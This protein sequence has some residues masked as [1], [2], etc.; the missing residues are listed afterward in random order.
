MRTWGLRSLWLGFAGFTVGLIAWPVGAP[1]QNLNLQSQIQVYSPPF[2][3]Q[4]LGPSRSITVP[5]QQWSA[6]K[7]S[8]LTRLLQA[9]KRALSHGGQKKGQANVQKFA[10]SEHIKRLKELSLAGQQEYIANLSAEDIEQIE[11]QLAALKPSPTPI[12]SNIPQPTTLKVTLPILD[13]T[14]ETNVLK[15]DQNI[16]PDVSL[17]LGG[18]AQVTMGLSKDRPWDVAA[19]SVAEASA[20]YDQNPSKSLDVITQSAAYQFFL[21]ATDPGGAKI[22]PG[23]E[24]PKA[25]RDPTD[26]PSPGVFTVD[27]LLVGLQNQTAFVPTF[28][29]ET[30][31]L[32]TPQVVYTR[33]NIDLSGIAPCHAIQ[34]NA[35]GNCIYA[36]L[37]V[38]L[39]QTF[40][41]QPTQANANVA[42]GGT[43]GFR[44]NKTDL[45]LT[46]PTIVTGKTYETFA[47]GRRD[48]VLQ[49]GPALS[50]TP[51]QWV[52]ASLAITYYDQYSSVTAAAWHG[53]IIQPTL[54]IT[55]DPTQDLG[56]VRRAAD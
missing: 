2:V 56:L 36:D 6:F 1:A 35:A 38:G 54:S 29:A 26:K 47:G 45:V 20:R 3:A 11:Q 37:S 4:P 23:L 5:E 51:N 55:F 9:K 30:A 12:G 10:A 27:T 8:A 43:L 48:L 13:P 49:T 25:D 50:W 32:L 34:N 16:R 24:I 15:T 42:A 19:F 39:G 31:D 44:I 7:W 41:D 28:H 52:T 53:W 46:I 14:Y 40:S 17:G 18:Q 33:Q 21:G 22:A